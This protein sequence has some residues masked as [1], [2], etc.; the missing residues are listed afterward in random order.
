M[1]VV[2]ILGSGPNVVESR[3]WPRAQFDR[4]VAINNAWA[5]RPDWD[6][7]IHPD[8]FPASRMPTH[9]AAQQRVVRAAQ[10]VPLQ[11][12]HGGFVYAGGTMAFTASYW[13][14][15]ALKPKVIA[16]I[17]CDMVYDASAQTHFYGKG[18][19]DPLRQDVTLRALEAKSARLMALAARQGCAIVNLSSNQSRLVFPRA[20]PDALA[21]I[22]PA[23]YDSHIVDA[24][25]AQEA[26]L[27]YYVP[28]GK[29]WKE[30][31]RF[32]VAAIDALDALWLTTI[33]DPQTTP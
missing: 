7:L 6:D 4:I 28:S 14:L 23:P 20:T 18:T 8:D 21:G 22:K 16:V 13:A 10:Y 27:G 33:P 31:G 17:G 30:E 12:E 11:N 26:A 9:L 19:A 15:A 3:S 25:L 1:S 32:D 2:L 5:V 24:A 29:Y